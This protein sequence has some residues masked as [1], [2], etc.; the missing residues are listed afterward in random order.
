MN[1]KGFWQIGNFFQKVQEKGLN[2]VIEAIRIKT[3]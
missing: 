2:K 3:G 1:I